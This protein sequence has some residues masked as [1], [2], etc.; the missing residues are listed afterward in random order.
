MIKK[1]SLLSLVLCFLFA[2]GNIDQVL[3]DIE[4]TTSTKNIIPTETEMSAGLKEALVKGTT[5][6]VSLLHKEG[7]YLEK[8]S[9]K[10]PFPKELDH[11]ASK[12]IDLGFESQVDQLVVSLNRAAED[13]VIEAK[14]IFVD[15][16]SAMTFADVRNILVGEDTAATHY[17]KANTSADLKQAFQPKIANSLDKVNATKYWSDLTGIYNK[18]PFITKV[19]ED[20][21]DYVT[22]RALEGL[23]MQIAQEEMSIR[24]NPLE[25]STDLLKKVFSYAESQAN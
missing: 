21:S 4:Q 11:V 5:S 25:R 15:A 22:S 13:A 10:I 3:K 24:E 18:I 6:G 1:L 12:L 23:F 16:I 19:N 17:L 9:L 14:P 20:L 7:G 8:P 2:C